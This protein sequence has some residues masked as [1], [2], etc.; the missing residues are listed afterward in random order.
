VYLKSDEWRTIR[1]RILRKCNEVCEKCSKAKATD[2]HHMDYRILNIPNYGTRKELI[3]LCRS[4]HDLVEDAIKLK[5]LY[6]THSREMLSEI[7]PELVAKKRKQLKKRI[8]WDDEMTSAAIGA[9]TNAQRM[10]CGMLKR[11]YPKSWSEWNGIQMTLRRREKILEIF[12]KVKVSQ[13]HF[14]SNWK[15][16]FKAKAHASIY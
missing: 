12:K 8:T 2:V 3:G 11:Q 15:V 14:G 9:S 13:K 10:V 4:C 1:A 6:R 7:T 16:R 5:L